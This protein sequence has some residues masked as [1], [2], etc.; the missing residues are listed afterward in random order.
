MNDLK[1]DN[2]NKVNFRTIVVGAKGSKD[3]IKEAKLDSHGIIC[4]DVNGK[5]VT[6]V[7]GHNYKK[8][9]VVAA[10]NKLLHK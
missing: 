5:I 3:A 10:M 8:E 4:R 1:K 2:G 6:T 7:N 9:K